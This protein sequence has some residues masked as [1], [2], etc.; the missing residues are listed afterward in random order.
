MRHP[1]RKEN[2][3]QPEIDDPSPSDIEGVREDHENEERSPNMPESPRS[4][5][6]RLVVSLGLRRFIQA[7]PPGSEYSSTPQL[8]CQHS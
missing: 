7:Q 1:T 8:H 3:E 5:T 2:P 6:G 4:D